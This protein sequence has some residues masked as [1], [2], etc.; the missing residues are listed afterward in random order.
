MDLEQYLKD[1]IKSNIG[2]SPTE[3]IT[4]Y[5]DTHGMAKQGRFKTDKKR[6]IF[7]TLDKLF[8]KG[9]IIFEKG[10]YLLNA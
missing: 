3:I 7:K 4:A 5:S 10:K 9:E 2:L 1:I 8:D 6:E